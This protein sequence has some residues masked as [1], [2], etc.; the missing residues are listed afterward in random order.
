M[1]YIEDGV[2]H[3]TI[4]KLSLFIVLAVRWYPIRKV[5]ARFFSVSAAVSTPTLRC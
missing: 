4:A 2:C 3:W 5:N 1:K